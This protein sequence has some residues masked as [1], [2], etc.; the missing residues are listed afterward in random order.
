MKG[1][2]TRHQR[3]V[4]HGEAARKQAAQV[5][6]AADLH[7]FKHP[8]QSIHETIALKIESIEYSAIPAA[9]QH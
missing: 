6:A 9:A 4:I 2:L 5:Q 8:A 7:Q 1:R 3:L